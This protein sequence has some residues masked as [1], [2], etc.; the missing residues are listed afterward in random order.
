[1][2]NLIIEEC[3]VKIWCVLRLMFYALRWAPM[4]VDDVVKLDCLRPFQ[5]RLREQLRLWKPEI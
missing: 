5:E 2:R 4:P 3:K 1:M